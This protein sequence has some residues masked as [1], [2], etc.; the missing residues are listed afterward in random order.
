MIISG[1]FFLYETTFYTFSNI[2][3]LLDLRDKIIIAS[4]IQMYLYK[5]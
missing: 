3:K 1:G 2:R 4:P 5:E